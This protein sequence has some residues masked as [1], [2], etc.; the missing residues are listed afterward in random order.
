MKAHDIGTVR[1]WCGDTFRLTVWFD[2]GSFFAVVGHRKFPV[3][4]SP[5]TELWHEVPKGGSE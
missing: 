2:D 5:D 1:I 4:F 3:Q